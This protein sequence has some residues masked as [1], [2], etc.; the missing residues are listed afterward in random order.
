MNKTVKM[1]F[2]KIPFESFEREYIKTLKTNKKTTRKLIKNINN[3]TYNNKF[4]P[5]DDFYNWV[6]SKRLSETII[7]KDEKYIVQYDDFRIVQHK[8]YLE[9]FD[10]I[11][12]YLKKNDNTPFYKCLKTYYDSTQKTSSLSEITTNV[13]EKIKV[14]DK[15]RLNKQNVWKMLALFNDSELYSWGCPLVYNMLPDDKD[16]TTFRCKINGPRFSLVDMDVTSC[17]FF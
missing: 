17:I 7:Q 14:I 12:K 9:L 3:F 11:K 16:P 8:V 5:Q 2:H 10:I 13:L 1:P 4:T 15:L 6:N